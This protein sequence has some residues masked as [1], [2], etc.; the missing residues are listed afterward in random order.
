MNPS[1]ATAHN[2][3]LTAHYSLLPIPLPITRASHRL[4]EIGQWFILNNRPRIGLHERFSDLFSTDFRRRVARCRQN[5]H[6]LFHLVRVG[7]KHMHSL[8]FEEP[9]RR[10]PRTVAPE[11]R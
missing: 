2:S 1:L 5:R 6:T 7:R 3:S 11:S 10:A 8:A 4:R 9:Q